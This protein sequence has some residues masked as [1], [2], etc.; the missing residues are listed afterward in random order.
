MHDAGVFMTG[1]RDIKRMLAYSSVEHMGILVIGMGM[2]GM[3]IF[4]A[5]VPLDNN[6]MTKGVL[7]LSAGSIRRAYDSK[8]IDVI[9]GAMRRLPLSGTLFLFGFIAITGSPP[10]GPFVSEFTIITAAFQGGRFVTGGLFLLFLLIV[11][12]GM[13]GTVLAAVQG[14]PSGRSKMI[15]YR[16]TFLTGAPVVVFMALSLLLGLWLP[17]PLR[18]LIDQAAH[19][20]ETRP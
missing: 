14:R 5:L 20:L 16:D 2:G 6:A 17:N 4:G 3:G 13:G 9:S 10:F 1:Q 7:F 12:T 15:P 11:F 18:T 19:Y 8:S